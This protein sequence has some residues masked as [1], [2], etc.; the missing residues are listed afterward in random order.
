MTDDR[1]KA[2]AFICGMHFSN[3]NHTSIFDYTRGAYFYLDYSVNGQNISVYDYERKCYVG[4]SFSSLYDYGVA[5]YM[6]CRVVREGIIDVYDYLTGTNLQVTCR[7][8][9]VSLFDY[10]AGK[11]FE[12]QLS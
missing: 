8:K 1:R 6:D 5:R 12:Y 10:K 7:G 2:I 4:G 3:E 9:N 11:Y